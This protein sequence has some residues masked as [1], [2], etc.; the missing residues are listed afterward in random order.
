MSGE[1]VRFGT[2]VLEMGNKTER[3]EKQ[4]EAVREEM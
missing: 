4:S 3:V 1:S 2:L